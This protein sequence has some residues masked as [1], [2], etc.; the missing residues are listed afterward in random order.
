MMPWAELSALVAPHRWKGE[1]GRK[2]VGL[3]TLSRL[4]FLQQWFALG[5]PGVEDALYE[6]PVL[7]PF[8]G[9]DLGRAPAPDE[10]TT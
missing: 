7:R 10:T 2:P 6:S 5:D 3:D 9:L 4:Y 8:A 1:A